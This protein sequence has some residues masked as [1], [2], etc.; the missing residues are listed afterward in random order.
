MWKP[1][2]QA[3]GPSR[4]FGFCCGTAVLLF[5]ATACIAI[6]LDVANRRPAPLQNRVE[7]GES[8]RWREPT[9]EEF[10][11]ICRQFLENSKHLKHL[12]EALDRGLKCRCEMRPNVG[13]G[14][15]CYLPKGTPI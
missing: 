6:L 14:I 5:S 4:F 9:P 10:R 8:S 2:S 12:Q 13:A 7:R 15:A 1:F 3:D 11:V